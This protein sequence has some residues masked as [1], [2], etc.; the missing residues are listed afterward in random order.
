MKTTVELPDALFRQ[1]KARAASSGVTLKSFL[2]EALEA[3]LACSAGSGGAKPW[4]NVFAGLRRNGAFQAETARIN[5]VIEDEFE[6]I[7]P[8]DV[9]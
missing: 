7:E 8:E 3:R 2:T 6:R 1:A 5:A 4:M 9:A